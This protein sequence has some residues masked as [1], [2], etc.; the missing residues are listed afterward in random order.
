MCLYTVVWFQVFLSNNKN[1]K[2]HPF[3]LTD[4]T[5]PHQSAPGSNDNEG[6]PHASDKI[7]IAPKPYQLAGAVEYTDCMSVEE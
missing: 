3:D 5:T 4:T 2:T 7:N 6:V 1:F